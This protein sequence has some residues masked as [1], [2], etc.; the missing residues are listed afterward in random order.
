VSKAAASVNTSLDNLV[1]GA[2]HGQW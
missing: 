1:S 2:T